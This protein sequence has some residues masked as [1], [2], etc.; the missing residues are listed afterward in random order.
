M[1]PEQVLGSAKI[2]GAT[3]YLCMNYPDKFASFDNLTHFSTV[4]HQ[5][6]VKYIG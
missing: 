4:P 2:M 3:M 6:I 1:T 5:D